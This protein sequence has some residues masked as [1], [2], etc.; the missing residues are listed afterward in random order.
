MDVIHDEED[1]RFYAVLGQEEAELTY[2]Y[3]EDKVLDLDYTFVPEAYRNQGLADQLVKAGLEFV[4]A[5]NYRFI[6][7]CPVVE[8][9]VHRHPE[10]Q[11]LMD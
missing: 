9:Y 5:R 10:Y 6:P 1:L 8:A 3:S 2:T 4:K 11:A 7:S